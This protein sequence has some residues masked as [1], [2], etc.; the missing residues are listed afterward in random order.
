MEFAPNNL[1]KPFESKQSIKVPR[2]KNK[3]EDL[4]T[5]PLLNPKQCFREIIN[6]ILIKVVKTTEDLI[7]ERYKNPDDPY[8]GDFRLLQ[9]MKTAC[10]V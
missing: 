7:K 8:N 2:F 10:N 4:S 6:S 9:I 5:E 3:I 1:A